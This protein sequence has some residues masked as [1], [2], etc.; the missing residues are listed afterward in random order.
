MQAFLKL[1]ETLLLALEK[2]ALARVPDC[3]LIT[4]EMEPLAEAATFD[5]LVP[6]IRVMKA[7]SRVCFLQGTLKQGSV[8]V[9]KARAIFR[10][11]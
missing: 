10:Q 1:S 7:S 4:V 9:L 11:K 3:H 6:D 8:P 5:D 2:E